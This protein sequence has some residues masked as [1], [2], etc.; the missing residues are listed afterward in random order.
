MPR[1]IV[2]RYLRQLGSGT[3]YGWTPMLAK[4]KD[5]Q[6]ID[7]ASARVRIDALKEQIKAR[8][9][10]ITNPARIAVAKARLETINKLSKELSE[11][12]K[13][14]AAAEEE[15]RKEAET[16]ILAQTP[17][18]K[19]DDIDTSKKGPVDPEIIEEERKGRILTEDKEYQSILAMKTGQEITNYLA[20]NF[21]MKEN[22]KQALEKLR[23]VAL[24][25]RKER[26]FEV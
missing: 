2:G 23:F 13:V 26:V 5:M 21:G 20:A 12:E 8:I 7:P 6:E 25:K 3:I 11:L 10:N 14:T 24:E 1:A 15:Q 19:P 4:R 16:A 22:P 18:L 17:A 9:E